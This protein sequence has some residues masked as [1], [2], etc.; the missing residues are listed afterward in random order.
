MVVEVKGGLSVC[1]FGGL[2]EHEVCEDRRLLSTTASKLRGTMCKAKGRV[3][4]VG[5][6]M[7][8]KQ[9]GSAH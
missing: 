4:A 2:G 5:L 6:C 9:A 1:F 7:A 3:A 8:I